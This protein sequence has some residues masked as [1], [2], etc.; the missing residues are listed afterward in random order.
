MAA[1]PEKGDNWKIITA[2]VCIGTLFLIVVFLPRLT[3]L[4]WFP[5]T[6]DAEK[7]NEQ[8]KILGTY[9][10]MFGMLNSIF[11]G[12]ALAGAIYAVILQRREH[13]SNADEQEQ[14]ER[15]R[16]EA[17]IRDAWVS[18]LNA[19]SSLAS[20]Y[21]AHYASNAQVHDNQYRVMIS[22]YRGEMAKLNGENIGDVRF[23]V[24][25]MRLE[26][27]ELSPEEKNLVQ[28]TVRG[29]MMYYRDQ[30][31]RFLREA[32]DQHVALHVEHGDVLQAE[33]TAAIREAY[34]S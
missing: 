32:N 5:R 1:N 18:R 14:V 19:A 21:S 29:K 26:S 20:A 27:L 30:V 33:N 31:E 9:G 12:A 10:D 3:L 13:R 23:R 15:M 24:S 28:D 16:R 11:S 2:I 4:S 7:I 34:N 6:K 8:I 25:T 22:N 17:S